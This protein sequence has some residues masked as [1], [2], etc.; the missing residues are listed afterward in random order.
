M[1]IQYRYSLKATDKEKIKDLLFSTGFFHKYEIDVAVEIAETTLEK[2]E[3]VA[4]YHFIIAEK[5]DKMLG[6][7]CFG[8]TPCTESSFDLYW[9]AVHKSDMNKGIG[10]I[11][12]EKSEQ[13]VKNMNGTHF[14]IETSSRS[15]YLPT[16]RF[17]E[18]KGYIVEAE[19]KDFYARD[20]NKLIFRKVIQ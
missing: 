13:S 3:E 12:L 2:G 8:K 5:N 19:L 1:D 4:G 11:L 17:Y 14:W 18:K 20:D 15:I 9:I 10:G 6:F 7:A 16:R